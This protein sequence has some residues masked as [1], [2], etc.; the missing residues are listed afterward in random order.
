[1]V[2]CLIIDIWLLFRLKKAISRERRKEFLEYTQES[3]DEEFRKK[4]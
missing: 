1:M 4:K 2:G 3:L